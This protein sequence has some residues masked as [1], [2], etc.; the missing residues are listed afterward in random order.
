M[1]ML[2]YPIFFPKNSVRSFRDFLFPAASSIFILFYLFNL[3]SWPFLFKFLDFAEKTRFMPEST[4]AT[5]GNQVLR[6]FK[7]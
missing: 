4:K 5:D 3:S 7:I 6:P 1:Y 2:I